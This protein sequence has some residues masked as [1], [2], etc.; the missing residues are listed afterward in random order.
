MRG[1]LNDHCRFISRTSSNI[2]RC[3]LKRWWR[4]FLQ[5]CTD[6]FKLPHQKPARS[7]LARA[8]RGLSQYVPTLFTLF[9][10]YGIE[11]FLAWYDAKVDNFKKQGKVLF[12]SELAENIREDIRDYEEMTAFKHY[13]YTSAE[14]CELEDHI[15]QQHLDYFKKFYKVV[16]CN[17]FDERHSNFMN[18]QEVLDNG[19]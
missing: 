6:R 14:D 7:A 12:K 19:M 10:E 2:S 15:Q 11:G 13:E 5:G 4:D 16:R 18:G 8:D 17:E 9:H 1:V 3:P